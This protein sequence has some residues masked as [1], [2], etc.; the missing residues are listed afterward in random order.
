LKLPLSTTYVTFMVAM[1]SSFA[2]RAWDRESAVYRIAGVFNV[3]GGW[4][5][6]AIIAFISAFI[7]AFLLKVGEVFAFVGLLVSLGIILYRSAKKY[8]KKEKEVQELMLL[9]REDIV[10]IN[11]V[12]NE[13]S[14]QI[15]HVIRS[16]NEI[17]SNVIDNLGLQD[18]G[19]LK[20]NKKVLK[21]LEKEVDELKTNVY[22]FIKNL[23]ETSVEASMF[24]I[25]ILGYLQDMIQSL[26]LISQNSY[27]HIDNNHKQL[28]F[29]QIRDLKK[30]DNELMALFD[31]IEVVFS[32]NTFD[33]ISNLVKGRN[34]LLEL[35]SSL[36]QKQIGRIRTVETSPKNSK[37]YFALLLET[38]DLIKATMSL[39][40]L[41]N[42]FNVHANSKVTKL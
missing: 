38:N 39:L 25:M 10:T 18:L 29:N 14:A 31:K 23:D 11:E 27:N 20:E 24:Y 5:F 6:T 22:Y 4:F 1:G 3:I 13:S 28:K 42:E 19:K 26:V 37:L 17:Y 2:D 16:T 33:D 21:K 8:T 32:D 30:V 40:E 15:S 7:I 35:V 41:F 36:I 34:E 9:K 12:I